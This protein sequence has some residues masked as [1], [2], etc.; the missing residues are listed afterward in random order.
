[1][2][3]N[4]KILDKIKKLLE[5]SKN[6][7]EHEAASAAARA[8]QL[9]RDH[10]ISSAML[11]T[12]DDSK[13]SEPI[14]EG[15]LDQDR[16]S[17]KRVAWKVIIAM[18][19]SRAFGLSETWSCGGSIRGFG[20]TTAVQS[21]SYLCQYLF[22]EVDRLADL[23]WDS[24]IAELAR[25]NEVS[26]RAWK[27]GFRVGA[28]SVIRI[29]LTEQARSQESSKTRDIAIAAADTSGPDV[30]GRETVCSQALAIIDRERAEVQA[31][32]ER[33]AKSFGRSTSLGTTS[34]RSGVAAGR[35]A[36]RAVDLGSADRR[37][38]PVPAKS[39]KP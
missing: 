18:G 30:A 6:T 17:G 12:A 20:R 13:T 3:V 16:V 23:A 34:S 25:S 24:D 37:G 11:S 36:G 14:I 32:Y 28:A 22:R 9:M 27:N 38:L 26:V 7:N 8:A 4:I 15:Q 31:A 21:W 35:A 19:A 29:R 39:I 5:L 33:K 2:N 10:E 1:M